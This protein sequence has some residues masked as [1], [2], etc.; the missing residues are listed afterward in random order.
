MQDLAPIAVL[1]Y[2]RLDHL[3][4]TVKA[5][6]K[7]SLARESII[8][9]FS[10]AAQ[11]GDEWKVQLLREYLK[12]VT[13][14]K[15]IFLEERKTNSYLENTVG[16][17][18]KILKYYGKGIILEDDIVT[19]SGFLKYMNDALNYYENNDKVFSVTGYSPPISLPDDY[20]K[21]YFTLRRFSG[22]GAGLWGSKYFK[23]KPLTVEEFESADK[24][25]I[26]TYGTD[27]LTMMDKQ[28][29]GGIRANDVNMMFYQYKTDMMTIYPKKSLVQNIGH[30]GSGVHCGVS[31][32]F[33]HS[34][35]WDKTKNFVFD[36]D[37]KSNQAII[38]ANFDFRFSMN[39]FA[40]ELI[41]TDLMEKIE[42]LKGNRFSIYG[43]GELT[44]LLFTRLH[45][46]RGDKIVR[47]LIDSTVKEKKSL[48]HGY[49]IVSPEIAIENGETNFVLASWNGRAALR[50]K[51][52]QLT[53]DNVN[54]K[55]LIPEICN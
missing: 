18:E 24:K 20:V 4:Q 52:K 43:I 11:K 10:D 39:S 36:D 40:K 26:S 48:F 47:Y 50:E 45:S 8:Y 7:N 32:K 30:D 23:M 53:S 37:I 22:W 16:N 29:K 49:K 1:T 3:K 28:A 2:T 42:K 51:L 55:I 33:Y 5:L 17:V 21:D 25:N 19:A 31:D 14:F 12:T 15:K 41:I 27:L 54:I 34:E 9:F 44:Q 38:R 35:L 46:S 13:G 6:Q